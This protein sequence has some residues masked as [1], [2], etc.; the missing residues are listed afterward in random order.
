M[1]K[2]YN[3]AS[4]DSIYEKHNCIPSYLVGCAKTKDGIFFEYCKNC[5]S[6]FDRWE[7]GQESEREKNKKPLKKKKSK[8]L[9]E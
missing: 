1:T 5:S 2:H 4:L 3:N 7:N 8:R 9:E 6:V